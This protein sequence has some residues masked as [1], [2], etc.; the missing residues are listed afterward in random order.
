MINNSCVELQ[1]QRM[2]ARGGKKA[3]I[4]QELLNNQEDIVDNALL[5]GNSQR[6]R[7]LTN[8]DVAQWVNLV[9]QFIINRPKELKAILGVA[10]L[11]ETMKE[12]GAKPVG[13]PPLNMMVVKSKWEIQGFT[14]TADTEAEG[15]FS[16]GFHKSSE[17]SLKLKNESKEEK[18]ARRAAAQAKRA[19]QPFSKECTGCGRVFKGKSKKSVQGSLDNHRRKGS[20][21]RIQNGKH[22]PACKNGKRSEIQAVWRQEIAN[23]EK[24]AK[25]SLS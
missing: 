11:R 12:M 10:Q 4:L 7:P 13:T 18:A 19:A 17:A 3:T 9:G 16:C 20:T 21:A 22:Y 5:A 2:Q 25:K 15:A 8:I 1:R 24:K 6:L 14:P 23:K